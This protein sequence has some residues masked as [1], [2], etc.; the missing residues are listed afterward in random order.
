MLIPYPIISC[1]CPLK[2]VE[3][4][5]SRGYV[6]DQAATPKNGSLEDVRTPHGSIWTIS[7]HMFIICHVLSIK[8]FNAIKIKY[9][10]GFPSVTRLENRILSTP[11]TLLASL[12]QNIQG[13]EPRKAWHHGTGD[14]T[15]GKMAQGYDN[16][17]GAI[18]STKIHNKN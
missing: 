8:P 2:L 5:A 4:T 7:I 15:K 10:S 9:R 1:S 16:Y 17:E 13:F 18:L 11:R 6:A 12:M 14:P 3:D